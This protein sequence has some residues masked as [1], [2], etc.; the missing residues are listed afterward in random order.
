[1]PVPGPAAIPCLIL[2]AG[3]ATRYG[4]AKQLAHL[5]GISLVRRAVLT[6]QEAGTEPV[7][8]IGAYAD[9]VRAELAAASQVRLIENPDWAEGMGSSIATGVRAL[10]QRRPVPSAVVILLA[11]QPCVGAPALR[12]L[13]DLHREAPGHPLASSYGD[14]QEWGPPCLFPAGL[15]PEL[16]S[17][18]G[19]RG[20][21]AV[22]ERH[23]GQVR[24]LPFPDAG[25]DIDTPEDLV[26][27]AN[28]L[29]R[30]AGPSR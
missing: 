1:M 27:A 15:F 17:L 25:W 5:E 2:A 7:V 18:S 9:K 12:A 16:V 11:D 14:G 4:S 29:S 19:E 3:A 26:R 30:P 6:A 22:L 13:I 28:M 21:R 20:A 23:L 8:V 10:V 24:R